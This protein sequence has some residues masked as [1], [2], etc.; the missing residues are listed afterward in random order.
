MHIYSSEITTYTTQ[1]NKDTSTFPSTEV[2]LKSSTINFMSTTTG[3]MI[4]LTQESI[5]TPSDDPTTSSPPATST[6]IELYTSTGE[7]NFESTT[8]ST[9]SS[10]IGTTSNLVLLTTD[11]STTEQLSMGSM[12]VLSSS[13][14]PVYTDETAKDST[15]VATGRLTTID[16][17]DKST[18]RTT[19]SPFI[20]SDTTFN[21]AVIS[22]TTFTIVDST[23]SFNEQDTESFTS[24][25]TVQPSTSS[26]ST[27]VTESISKTDG[28]TP[29]QNLNLTTD[30]THSIYS[31]TY[32]LTQKST[33]HTTS[34]STESSSDSTFAPFVSEQEST[35][36][37][38]YALTTNA[39][40]TTNDIESTFESSTTSFA[41]E[42]TEV[43][44]AYSAHPSTKDL[45][46]VLDSTSSITDSTS[47][48]TIVDESLLTTQEYSTS[49]YSTENKATHT[50]HSSQ[51]TKSPT[52]DNLATF[53]DSSVQS[54]STVIENFF[55]YLLNP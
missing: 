24:K 4:S 32:G 38:T 2:E 16:V 21:P 31:S 35:S 54:T 40:F 1:P 23:T 15:F 9:V 10:T 20:A 5:L 6:F 42:P 8:E 26:V 44:T 36:D 19:N 18:Q 3:E 17:P 55:K 12:F 30:S 49:S 37:L 22:S 25:A 45:P 48:S 7:S 51:T 41:Y 13:S 46:T 14:A 11:A 29:H 34:I 47:Y 33:E 28:S 39:L 50:T 43:T 27:L 53:L 52:T